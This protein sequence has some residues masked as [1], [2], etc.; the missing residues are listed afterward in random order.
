MEYIAIAALGVAL[1]GCGGQYEEEYSLVSCTQ[2]TTAITSSASQV[3]LSCRDRT[4]I[5][6]KPASGGNVIDT[7]TFNASTKKGG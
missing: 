2:T 1:A 3:T 4:E 7:S 6:K 5:N